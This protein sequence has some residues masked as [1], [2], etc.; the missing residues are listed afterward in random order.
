MADSGG[1][2]KAQWTVIGMIF[3]IA[4][5]DALIQPNFQTMI[6]NFVGNFKGTSGNNNN[7][8]KT[9]YTGNTGTGGNNNGP[10]QTVP[11]NSSNTGTSLIPNM[12]LQQLNTT[13]TTPTQLNL[14]GQ[15][16]QNF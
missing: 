3:V 10:I 11:L 13:Q 9:S 5:L 6:K 14:G 4:G 12:T 8:N 16:P 15:V 2:S 7:N 1:V